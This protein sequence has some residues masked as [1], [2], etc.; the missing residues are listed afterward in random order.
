MLAGDHTARRSSSSCRK[1]RL[2]SI[3]NNIALFAISYDSIDTLASFAEKHGITYP[4]LSDNSGKFIREIGMLN[5][6]LYEQQAAFG[7]RRNESQYGV[8]YP[9]TFV[10]D[11]RGTVADKRF[12]QIYRERETGVGLLESALRI[13][14]PQHGAERETSAQAVRVRAYLD[15][16]TFAYAQRL[17]LTVELTLNPGFHVYGRPV[18]DGFI[19]L[20]VT[21]EPIN[22]IDV[23]EAEWPTPHRW[24]I[25]GLDEEFWVY[26]ETVHGSIP[27]TFNLQ[28]GSGD[29]LVRATVAFQVCDATTCLLPARVTLEL[30][31]EEIGL[32]D[33]PL[34]R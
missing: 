15:S 19:P 27:L 11:E 2:N 23:G 31:V 16:P 21:I 12:Y 6:H 8:P 10:L 5:E 7:M 32:V 9:G 33:R 18:P 25:E 3:K 22:R 1:S 28:P 14:S 29:Q 30:P 26:G 20:S 17:H 34:P 24:T 13:A 4:L